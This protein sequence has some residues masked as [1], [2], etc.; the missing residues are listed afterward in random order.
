MRW[1]LVACSFILWVLVYFTLWKSVRSSGRVL[2]VTATAPFG[3]VLVF[4]G[5]ALSLEGSDIGLKY[6]FQPKWELLLDSKVSFLK[7]K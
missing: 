2:Y 1:E 7:V 3:L 5:H 6:L 4:L